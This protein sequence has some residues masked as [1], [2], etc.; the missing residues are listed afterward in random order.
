[1]F[2][3]MH[4]I[5]NDNERL[6]RAVCARRGKPFTSFHRPHYIYNPVSD[7]FSGYTVSSVKC[8]TCQTTSRVVERFT[9]LMLDLPSH[10]QRVEFAKQHPEQVSRRCAVGVDG[11]V[12]R[13]PSSQ[14][15]CKRRRVM[16]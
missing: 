8:H 5:D 9:S 13:Q 14:F 1:M 16:H 2:E 10:H 6:E 4:A 7:T 11:Q 12:L 3:L 15:H